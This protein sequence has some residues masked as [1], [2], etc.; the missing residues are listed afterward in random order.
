[1]S[2]GSFYFA[3]LVFL[4]GCTSQSDERPRQVAEK[5]L[6]AITTH[7]YDEAKK[8]GTPR[9]QEMLEIQS[10]VSSLSPEKKNSPCSIL[11]CTVDGNKAFV[12]YK[13]EKSQ[14]AEVLHLTRTKD[15][16]LVGQ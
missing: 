7:K 5:F 11:S 16:W 6:Q 4:A 15:D 2:R 14:D 10:S 12:V 3:A 1:M 13:R 8:Y 9:M